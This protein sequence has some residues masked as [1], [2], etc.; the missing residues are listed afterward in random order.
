MLEPLDFRYAAR[1]IFVK[2]ADQR[3]IFDL[4]FDGFWKLQPGVEPESAAGLTDR[5]TIDT[6]AAAFGGSLSAAA[7]TSDAD[8]DNDRP[9]APV[10][11]AAYSPTET[12]RL[13]D[14][15]DLSPEEVS[16]VERLIASRRW[17]IASK[18]SRRLRRSSKPGSLDLRRVLRA[19]IRHGGESMG[20]AWR[21]PKSK[22]RGLVLICDI[23]G[24]MSSYSR[25]LL[26]FAHALHQGLGEVESFVFG[27]RLTRITRLLQHRRVD[28]A[29][30]L[31]SGSVMDWSG[32]TRIG[33]SL[34]EFNRRWSRRLL[35]HGASVLIVSDGWERDDAGALAKEMRHLQR[36]A[37]RLIW[38]NP[39]LGQPGFEPLT[40]GLQAALPFVDDFLPVHNL[41]SLEELGA[42]LAETD[43]VR[44]VRRAVPA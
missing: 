44:P 21:R 10:V 18:A 8:R 42:N 31:V 29:L 16:E 11:L 4:L 34:R 22:R 28:N 3:Q 5:R 9:E 30:Q 7:H 12:L 15:Q 24:S 40:A 17:P 39:L 19:N 43:G 36:S 26:V 32:G 14:F 20:L 37:F 35:G 6:A 1:A 2:H 27:T 25:L 13:E 41:N 33:S 23:S 38:L